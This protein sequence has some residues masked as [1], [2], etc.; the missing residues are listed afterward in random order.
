MSGGPL[1]V[2]APGAPAALDLLERSDR[3]MRSV[4]LAVVETHTRALNH[5]QF[6]DLNLRSVVEVIPGM[7]DRRHVVAVYDHGQRQTDLGLAPTDAFAGFTRR[8]DSD[9]HREPVRDAR[10]LGA[11]SLRGRDTWVIWY[12]FFNQ[13]NDICG[14][15]WRTE[16]ID[17]ETFRLLRQVTHTCEAAPDA[18]VSVTVDLSYPG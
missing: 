2:S 13:L 1:A 12:S 4:T 17:A 14:P 7:P 15:V 11:D 18:D 3:A 10:L 5:H 6:A 8:S 16:W 9:S